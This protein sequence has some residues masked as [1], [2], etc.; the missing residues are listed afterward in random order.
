MLFGS[1][2]AWHIQEVSSSLQNSFLPQAPAKHL[3]F[4]VNGNN[5]V[6][7]ITVGIGRNDL[8]CMDN[9]KDILSR[10]RGLSS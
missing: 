10:N 1:L 4:G 5:V 8:A 2:H 7:C 6:T 9:I 3:A